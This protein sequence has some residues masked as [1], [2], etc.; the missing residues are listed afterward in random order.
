MPNKIVDN[1][2]SKIIPVRMLTTSV[3]IMLACT[4]LTQQ[5]AIAKTNGVVTDSTITKVT[6]PSKTQAAVVVVA[7][8]DEPTPLNESMVLAYA[9]K[10]PD[11]VTPLNE[12]MV[13]KYSAQKKA[14]SEKVNN[15]STESNKTAHP[16]IG[17]SD[18]GKY[19][20]D[21]AI[22]PDGKT[23]EVKLSFVV[24]ANGS[25]SGF[26]IDKSLSDAADKAAIDLV[27]TGPSWAYVANNQSKEVTLN[28]NFHRPT[29]L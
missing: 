15:T 8:E 6:P 12:A 16:Q 29:D 28:I 5:I 2:E 22:S 20:N 24:N 19:V 26:K 7:D 21:N 13:M 1:K 23:G 27:K 9:T 10:K 4:V 3:F 11:T 18:F 14:K 25:L 17:W